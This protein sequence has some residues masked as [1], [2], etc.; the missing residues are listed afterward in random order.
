MNRVST[1]G[2]Y[3]S[4]L[5]NLMAA[6]QRQT[7]AG[8]M[9]ATQKNGQDLKDYA[10][11][12]EMLTAMRSVETK[13]GGY[14]DQNKMVSDKLTTQDFALNQVVDA[15]QNSREAIEQALASGRVD[16][17]MQ[18][19][20]GY[21]R[22]ALEGL[23]TRYGGKYLF[24]GGKIDTRP[25]EGQTLQDLTTMYPTVDEFF[26][27]D[28]FKVEAK[29]DDSTTVRTGILA[30]EVGRDMMQMFKEIQE[31]HEAT[32]LSG[33]LT[34]AQRDY[35]KGLLDG[36]TST[37]GKSWDELHSDLVNHTARN[38]SVQARVEGVKADLDG[39]GGVLKSMIGEITDAD[40]A[41]AATALQQAQV[42]VQAAAQVFLSLQDSSL[43]NVLR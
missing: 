41:A 37:I 25:V 26:Q 30:N 7:K 40:M 2:N 19:L 14:L 11:N 3:A 5:A 10:R 8:E 4:V 42:S 38:G 13:L 6:S 15:A 24:S 21:F 9:V 22:N 36:S 39:R 1:T 16:T 34:D 28:D 27:N 29:I 33:Q 18:D 23:N 17:L 43:L 31:F 35:L 20:N 12:A 32:P